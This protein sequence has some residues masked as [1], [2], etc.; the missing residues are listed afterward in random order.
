M[1]FNSELL[2]DLADEEFREKSVQYM[3]AQQYLIKEVMIENDRLRK[4]VEK[5]DRRFRLYKKHINLLG[6]MNHDPVQNYIDDGYVIWTELHTLY[7]ASWNIEKSLE[8]FDF[9]S[10]TELNLENIEEMELYRGKDKSFLDF[11]IVLRLREPDSRGDKELFFECEEDKMLGYLE[12]YGDD[13]FL[14]EEEMIDNSYA[15]IFD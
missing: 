8:Y 7:V 5:K 9:Y 4:K 11:L 1:E 6:R 15:Y 10:D 3:T 14:S 2:K 12:K 13:V